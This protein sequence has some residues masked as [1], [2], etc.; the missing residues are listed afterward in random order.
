[1]NRGWSENP[2]TQLSY[3]QVVWESFPWGWMICGDTHCQNWAVQL[4]GILGQLWLT[5]G[6]GNEQYSQDDPPPRRCRCLVGGVLIQCWP[7]I[8]IVQIKSNYI[9]KNLIIFHLKNTMAGWV[10]IPQQ[11]VRW[12]FHQQQHGNDAYLSKFK[13][14][15]NIEGRIWK[16][17]KL[18]I[19]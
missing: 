18:A 3:V 8:H 16:H 19:V 2:T 14:N 4:A 17:I 9:H 6:G 5:R 12:S 10:P 15:W 11:M 13:W 7:Y 1:M